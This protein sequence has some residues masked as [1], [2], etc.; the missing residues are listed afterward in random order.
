MLL[1]FAFEKHVESIRS[2]FGKRS[3]PKKLVDN[4]L[5]RVAEN[6]PGQ[7]PEHQTKHGTGGHL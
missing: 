5:R 1:L 4:Q 3:Y 2:W 6:R 7:L